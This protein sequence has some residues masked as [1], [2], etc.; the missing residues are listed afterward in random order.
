[1][2]TKLGVDDCFLDI[3]RRPNLVHFRSACASQHISEVYGTV[4]FCRFFLP[5]LAYR[6]NAIFQDISEAHKTRA[7]AQG[8]AFMKLKFLKVGVWETIF[9][10][11]AK[12][13]PIPYCN[14]PSEVFS[15]HA[16][17]MVIDSNMILIVDFYYVGV[18]QS[19]PHSKV[20]HGLTFDPKLDTGYLTK[21]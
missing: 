11:P 19:V 1:M 21:V 10:K 17:E 9:Q 20:D 3:S 16:S 6:S 12:T 4:L 5:L 2:I 7:L 15:L 14:F 8:G 13:T 18:G